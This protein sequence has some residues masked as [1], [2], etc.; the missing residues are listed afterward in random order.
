M[1]AAIIVVLGYLAGCGVGTEPHLDT[2]TEDVVSPAPAPAEVVT[3]MEVVPPLVHVP[4]EPR[5]PRRSAKQCDVVLVVDDSNSM[6]SRITPVTN[7]LRVALRDRLGRFA[8]VRADGV[9]VAD[10]TD[11]AGIN[12]ALPAFG[13]D[14]PDFAPVVRD[15]L[16]DVATGRGLAYLPSAK[17]VALVFSDSPPAGRDPAPTGPVSVT[18]WVPKNQAADWVALGDVRSV[19]VGAL[20]IAADVTAVLDEECR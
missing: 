1:K 2:D 11:G 5:G 6:F 9:A 4:K 7:G 14:T 8:A 19:D 16:A 18:S 13:Q 15:V 17:R 3:V 20:D 12:A 10:F